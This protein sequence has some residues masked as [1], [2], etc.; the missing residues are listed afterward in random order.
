MANGSPP[1]HIFRSEFAQS[2]FSTRRGD[3]QYTGRTCSAEHCAF[4]HDQR[5]RNDKLSF[6]QVEATSTGNLT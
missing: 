6:T 5:T 4:D 1:F 2:P 3:T